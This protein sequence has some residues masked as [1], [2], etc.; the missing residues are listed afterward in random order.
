MELRR[1][2]P[3]PGI[4]LLPAERVD[5][6]DERAVLSL[7]DRSQPGL[8]VNAAAYTAVDRAEAEPERAFAINGRG[9]EI[10]AHW[11]QEHGATLLHVSTDYVFDGRKTTPYRVGDPTAPINTYGASKLAGE[12]AVRAALREHIIVRTSWVFSA[13]GQNFV[14]TIL[15][16]ARERDELRVVADQVGNPTHAGTLAEALL[17]VASRVASSRQLAWGTYH[18]V[19]AGTTSWHEFAQAIISAQ[20]QFTGRSPQLTAI[21]SSDYPTPAQRPRY[22]VLDDSSFR[23]AFAIP[24]RP[25]QQGLRA[26]VNELLGDES[27]PC[28]SL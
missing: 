15:R 7:L 13:H 24:A 17:M 26:T 18:L 20:A 2:A 12:A 1:A 9:P 23:E 8:V 6:G 25:W 11:C 3:V 4:E 16:L 22:S 10:L 19:D 27:G 28:G 5:L 14:K 21:S